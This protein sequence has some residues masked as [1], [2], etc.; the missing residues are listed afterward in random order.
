MKRLSLAIALLV[1]IQLLP[2]QDKKS[3]AQPTFVTSVEGVKEYRLDNG[4][5]I[6]LVPDPAINNVIVNVVYHVGSRNE[7]YG[8][9]GMAHLLEH[10]LFKGSKKFS[11]IK[12]TI[13]DKGATAN[14][15]TWYDRTDY[16]EILPANDSNLTW[17]LDMESDRMVNSLMKNEDLQKEFSV[18]RNEFEAGENYPDNILTERILSTMYVWHN[19]GK[20]TI[21]S[22]EDIERVPITNLT[23]F[24]Q[25]YYQPDNATLIVGGKI[26]EAK[27]LQWIAKYFAPITK[28]SR[29]LQPSYTV[30]PPQDGERFVE[31][32]RNGDISYIGMAFHTPSYADPDFAANRAAAN[33]LTN[34][35]SGIFYKALVETK[36]A[37]DVSGWTPTLYDPAFSYF[38]CSVPKGKSVDSAENAFRQTADQLATTSITQEDVDRAKNALEKQVFNFQNNTESFCIGLAEIIGAGDWRLFYL[39]RDRLEKL[40]LEDVQAALHKYYLPSNR[41]W[42]VFIPDKSADTERVAI[43]EHPDINSVLKNYKGRSTVARTETFEASIP[44]IKKHTEYGTLSNGMK[45]ALLKKPVKGDKIYA[46]LEFKVGDENSLTGKNI[47]PM[48]TARMLK[49]GTTSKSKKEINDALDKIKTSINISGGGPSISVSISTDSTNLDAAL[50]LLSDMMLHPSFD[51]AEYDKMVLDIKAELEAN[52]SDPQYLAIQA[53]E[54]KTRLYPKGHPFYPESIN[55]QLTDLQ[56][57]SLDQVKDFYNSFYGANNGYAAFVGSIN[58]P[59]IKSFFE[60]NF[61]NFTSKQ[62]YTEVPEKYFAVGGSVES[63]DVPDKKNAMLFARLNVPLKENDPDF[64]ALDIANEML[65]GGAFLSSRLPQRLRESEGMSYGAGS[66]LSST[67]KYP[68][69]SWGMYAIFNPTYKNRLDSAMRDVMT[70]ALKDGFKEDEFK[71]AVASWLQQRQTWLTDDRELPWR[72]TNYMSDGKDLSFYSD[73]EGKAKALTLE[74]VNAALRKYISLDKITFIYTGDFKEQQPGKL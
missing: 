43:A 45:Y 6:L 71:K 7:G 31:L 23:Q 62:H 59:A 67:Y 13:A 24:Y 58:A 29:M 8:E 61:S 46:N 36:L 60:K 57:V 27:T 66:F 56:N 30:E 5:Q 3:T 10:M 47:I 4:L 25:K 38:A 26:D 74:Q 53:V 17:A 63:I 18:V 16:F 64:V 2:A 34:D 72:L 52:A 32:R 70:T 9:T 11:N 55:E 40:T 44:N 12:Q 68:A 39:Y 22:K 42:G 21:G 1:S 28:P 51:K 15:T 37:T 19:Y 48:L 33:V 14:G 65:G 49:N 54:K 20:S 41:T 35:P 69:S 73:Y 50:E